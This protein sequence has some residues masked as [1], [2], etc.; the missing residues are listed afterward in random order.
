MAG[1]WREGAGQAE[2]PRGSTGSAK[3]PVGWRRHAREA[4]L[5][6]SSRRWLRTA[7]GLTAVV[8]SAVALILLYILLNPARARLYVDVA[9]Y[10]QELTDL[11]PPGYSTDP[12]DLREWLPNFRDEDV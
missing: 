12:R 3:A 6:R 2:P 1:R 8:A 11:V 9:S 5:Q 7:G 4:K 10:P